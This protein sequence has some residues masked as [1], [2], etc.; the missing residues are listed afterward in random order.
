M[1]REKPRRGIDKFFTPID[2]E[3]K[4]NLTRLR[5]RAKEVMSTLEKQGLNS[6]VHGSLARGDVSATSDVDICIL[7][8]ISSFQV[9]MALTNYQLVSR[10]IVQATPNYAVKG[11]IEL[12]ENTSITFPFVQLSQRELEFYQFGGKLTLEELNK[13]QFHPGVNKRLLLIEPTPDGFWTSSILTKKRE[14]TKILDVSL[15]VVEE[16]IRVLSRRDRVGRTGVFLLRELN[17]KEHFEAVLE[18]E[19]S[20][21]PALRRLVKRRT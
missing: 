13:D 2:E 1:P 8:P 10:K 21:N 14:V 17:P 16:R 19:I 18:E 15:E 20:T 5:D 7:I 3:R 6:I 11:I 4:T 9:E 12:D